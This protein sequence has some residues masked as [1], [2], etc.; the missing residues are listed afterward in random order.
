MGSFLHY[1]FNYS[2][3]EAKLTYPYAPGANLL[4]SKSVAQSQQ[5]TLPPGDLAI[6]KETTQ[7]NRKS[8]APNEKIWV[9][10]P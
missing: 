4:D 8:L 6:V 9:P 1:Y 3:A 2:S 10:Y 7:R 5:L